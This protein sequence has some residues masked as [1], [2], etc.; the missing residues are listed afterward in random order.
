MVSR[1]AA[2]CPAESRPIVLCRQHGRAERRTAQRNGHTR[3]PFAS[4][5]QLHAARIMCRDGV[6]VNRGR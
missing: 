1:H 5:H 2:F 3:C 6:V 4:P